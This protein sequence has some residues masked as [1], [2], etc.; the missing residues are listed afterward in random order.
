MNSLGL[1]EWAQWA[2]ALLVVV[3]YSAPFAM[4]GW[5]ARRQFSYEIPHEVFLDARSGRANKRR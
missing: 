5:V 4:I 2:I 1:P 3:G